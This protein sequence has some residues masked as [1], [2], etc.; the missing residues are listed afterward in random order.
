MGHTL[1]ACF[2]KEQFQPVLDILARYP[3]VN[4][5]PFGRGCDREEANRILP[6]HMTMFHWGKEMDGEMLMKTER[7]TFQESE[8]YAT[9]IRSMDAREGSSLLYLGVSLGKGY[10]AWE[11]QLEQS[12][13]TKHSSFRH[14]T[15]SV[16]KDHNEILSLKQ[17]LAIQLIFPMPLRICG[18]E[19]YH[20][21]QPV[22]FVK[23]WQK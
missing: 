3:S 7:I 6:F 13:G 5:I 18:M 9:G 16:S 19:L 22:Y 23:A 21:W 2:D 8:V 11:R 17:H 15:L 20:I 4:K 12:L 1:I 10:L 14:V